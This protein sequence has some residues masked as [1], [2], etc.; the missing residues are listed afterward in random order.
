MQITTRLRHHHFRDAFSVNHPSNPA[1][2]DQVPPFPPYL[3][4]REFS[5]PGMYSN[6][7]PSFHK[8]DAV[9]VLHPHGGFHPHDDRAPFMHSIHRLGIPPHIPERKPSSAPWGHQVPNPNL[10]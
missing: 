2:T 7:G 3:A 5:P 4:R 6:L 9:G 8:F 1:F 10:C